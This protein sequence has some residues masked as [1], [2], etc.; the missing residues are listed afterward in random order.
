LYKLAP[1]LTGDDTSPI[2]W[3]SV[4]TQ[5]QDIVYPVVTIGNK[6]I[7]YTFGEDYGSARIGG[8]CLLGNAGAGSIDKVTA[9]FKNYRV[10]KRKLPITVS[11]G[12]QAY[13]VYLTGLAIGSPEPA[14]NIQPFVLIGTLVS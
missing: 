6:K 7:L 12:S 3:T 10:S 2:I 5:D 1:G 9:Y 11:I 4:E 14:F 13:R 8:M